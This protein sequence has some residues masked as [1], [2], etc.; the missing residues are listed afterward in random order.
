MGDVVF[1]GV[2]GSD[3]VYDFD[4]KRLVTQGVCR[5]VVSATRMLKPVDREARIRSTIAVLER[6]GVGGRLQAIQA[7]S[8][9]GCPQGGPTWCFHT[10]LTSPEILSAFVRAAADRDIA[11][12]KL[13]LAHLNALARELVSRDGTVPDSVLAAV[14][15]AVVAFE[16]VDA[17]ERQGAVNF[18]MTTG[19]YSEEVL[20]AMV[21]LLDAENRGGGS[22][23]FRP[24]ANILGEIGPTAK[25]AVAGLLV[26]LK[27]EQKWDLK[28]DRAK[29]PWPN[30]PPG[31]RVE[32]C[33]ALGRIQATS[34]ISALRA[35]LRLGSRGA[36]WA[37][38]ALGPKAKVAIPDLVAATSHTLPNGPSTARL[39]VEAVLSLG[40]MGPS[41]TQTIPTLLSLLSQQPDRRIAGQH[42][43]I[44]EAAAIALGQ[45]GDAPGGG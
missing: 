22:F 19:R 11:V 21:R 28:L 9:D 12:R 24:I 44:R 18:L 20:A 13:A 42:A 8:S 14:P 34:A 41:A 17:E 26:A 6:G 43:D 35:E 45:I 2:C 16:S 29:F 31:P 25:P 7:L 1:A 32:I 40:K 33:R 3:S 30:G 39:W 36:A 15:H 38:G 27:H 10:V 5:T 23:Y 4:E 37:L